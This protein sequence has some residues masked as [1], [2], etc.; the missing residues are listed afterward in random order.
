M[1]AFVPLIAL[2]ALGV[3]VAVSQTGSAHAAASVAP[4]VPP[5]TGLA[6]VAVLAGVWRSADTAFT[7]PY[8]K[9]GHDTTTLHNDCW[10]NGPYFACD[11][12]V[13]GVPQGMIVFTASRNPDEFNQYAL[14]PRGGLPYA[15][16]LTISGATWTY[17]DALTDSSA[18][19]SNRPRF[20]TVNL[21][22]TS[23]EIRFRIEFTR[24]GQHWT[25]MREGVERKQR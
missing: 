4:P 24:D 8:S 5:D 23:S 3:A 20:R 10:R 2:A 22:M 21:F 11:Q 12:I 1:R 17:G 16:R 13:R 18:R 15:G 19:A 14:P 9:A 25:V 7:T 6:R